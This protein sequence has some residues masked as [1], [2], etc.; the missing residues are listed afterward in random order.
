MI[1]LLKAD[2]DEFIESLVREWDLSTGLEFCNGGW[3]E[4]MVKDWDLI[5]T[6]VW[7]YGY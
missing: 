1:V 6:H 5:R 4:L 3:V 2:D 7:S